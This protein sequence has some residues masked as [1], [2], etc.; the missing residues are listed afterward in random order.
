MSI[1]YVI[2]DYKKD[3]SRF[4]N[5]L[6]IKFR[7]NSSSSFEF[8]IPTKEVLS[9]SEQVDVGRQTYSIIWIKNT[10]FFLYPFKRILFSFVFVS[11]AGCGPFIRA[12][13]P[14]HN[15][16]TQKLFIVF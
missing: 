13:G 10:Y 4:Y 14:P 16:A 8:K 6:R 12:A 7:L 3:K 5:F 1:C 15:T 2:N 9:P 11:D